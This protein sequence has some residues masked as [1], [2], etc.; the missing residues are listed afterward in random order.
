MNSCLR[1]RTDLL[2]L[3]NLSLLSLSHFFSLCV[4]FIFFLAHSISLSFFLSFYLSFYL[5][6]FLSI[7][8]SFSY[9]LAISDPVLVSLCPTIYL[10]IYLSLT[11][12]IFLLSS[13]SIGSAHFLSTSKRAE[14][15]DRDDVRHSVYR[16]V[17]F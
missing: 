6:F 7:L 11:P 9:F 14:P 2:L 15:R 3:I 8:L 17:I 4:S 12:S 1:S 16:T 5:S 13:C 10:S